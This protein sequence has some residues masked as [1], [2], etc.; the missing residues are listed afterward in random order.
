MDETCVDQLA[1][2]LAHSATRRGIIGLLTGVAGLRVNASVAMQRHRAKDHAAGQGS[3][4]AQ[5]S[6]SVNTFPVSF[7]VE[8]PCTGEVVTAEGVGHS[9]GGDHFR[10]E[11]SGVGTSGATYQIVSVDNEGSAPSR[12][13]SVETAASTFR[14]I[15]EGGSGKDDFI[16]HGIVHLTINANGDLTAD[17]GVVRSRCI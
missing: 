6:V 12:R 9:V 16:A 17:F 13:T 11:L 8:S 5:G 3:A 4:T 15:R 7:T 14:L 2:T 10:Y 1:R